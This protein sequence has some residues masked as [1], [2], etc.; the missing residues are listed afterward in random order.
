MIEGGCHAPRPPSIRPKFPNDL[1]T[2]FD[3]EQIVLAVACLRTSRRSF[4]IVLSYPPLAAGALALPVRNEMDG[5]IRQ[6]PPRSR[7]MNEGLGYPSRLACRVGTG[8]RGCLRN[9]SWGKISNV[10]AP[11]A[12]NARGPPGLR[13]LSRDSE[14][15]ARIRARPLQAWIELCYDGFIAKSLTGSSAFSAAPASSRFNSGFTQRARP[16]GAP[17]SACTFC[18]KAMIRLHPGPSAAP[19]IRRPALCPSVRWLTTRLHPPCWFVRPLGSAL[20]AASNPTLNRA[21]V[22]SAAG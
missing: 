7:L 22:P 19:L 20:L 5:W 6:R 16:S 4:G 21:T 10:R 14:S 2:L 15:I 8:D 17:L 3:K 1:Y 18:S 11:D 9:T 12:G 13:S